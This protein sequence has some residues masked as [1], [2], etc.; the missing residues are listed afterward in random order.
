MRGQLLGS[1]V[2][3]QF[4][5][6]GVTFFRDFMEGDDDAFASRPGF[7]DQNLGD[8]LGDL[9]LLIGRA[10]GEHGD[11]DQG[12]KKVLSTQYSVPSTQKTFPKRD[13]W[14]LGTEH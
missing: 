14:V 5:A 1:F 3:H 4:A 12:H 11:L 7:F 8:A 13:N 10:A 6:G 2:D 9:A